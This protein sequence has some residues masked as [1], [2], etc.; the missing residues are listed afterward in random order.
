GPAGVG[1]APASAAPTPTPPRR[2][3]GPAPPP[4]RSAARRSGAEGGQRPSGTSWDSEPKPTDIPS[5]RK[6]VSA[7][8]ARNG[9]PRSLAVRGDGH[10]SG[11]PAPPGTAVAG[12]RALP[13]SGLLRSG[14]LGR[15][16]V[17]LPPGAVG[18]LLFLG[19]GGI[20]VRLHRGVRG[21]AVGGHVRG[22]GVPADV[23][24]RLVVH[25]GLRGVGTVVA[26]LVRDVG[27][28]AVH[29]RGLGGPS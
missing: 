16:G 21:L 1:S 15:L 14:L 3:W 5:G 19:G 29:R 26:L 12:R 23:G 4:A 7:R 9:P 25:H 28:G 10:P 11:L 13:R 22:V 8:P 6:G 24:L 18:P 2:A 20:E 27:R 17:L